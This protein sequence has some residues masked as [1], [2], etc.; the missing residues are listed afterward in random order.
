MFKKAVI[1]I[2]VMLGGR[3]LLPVNFFEHG[4]GSHFALITNGR[5]NGALS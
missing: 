1:F 4:V 2:W 3:P 5:Q